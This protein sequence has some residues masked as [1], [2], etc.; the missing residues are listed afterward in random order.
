MLQA[1]ETE[2]TLVNDDGDFIRFR[3]D[4]DNEELVDVIINDEK[5]WLNR[6]DCPHFCDALARVCAETAA[7][8]DNHEPA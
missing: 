1:K 2:L 5:F 4:P 3:V 6:E 7:E 8:G